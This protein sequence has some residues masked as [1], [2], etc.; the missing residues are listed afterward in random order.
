MPISRALSVLVVLAI[1]LLPV[2]SALV[3]PT[4]VAAPKKPTKPG[5]APTPNAQPKTKPVAEPTSPLPGSAPTP[6]V[7]PVPENMQ[8]IAGVD[9]QLDPKIAKALSRGNALSKSKVA[10]IA[11]K[12][13]IPADAND[14]LEATSLSVRYPYSGPGAYLSFRGAYQ[15]HPEAYPDGVASI[16]NNVDLRRV[17]DTG[18]PIVPAET[19][20]DLLR[21]LNPLHPEFPG[22]ADATITG[23][24]LAIHFVA[25]PDRDYVVSCRVTGTTVGTQGGTI[26]RTYAVRVVV[27]GDH[28]HMIR[29][30][31]PVN[32]RV[33]F[34]IARG[35]TKRG[36]D[37]QILAYK[38]DNL[39]TTYGFSVSRCD[40]SPIQ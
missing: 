10:S 39:P 25:A 4:A 2:V 30:L 18:P 5:P 13:S 24:Y 36:I 15:V 37:L 20:E 12:F 21:Q 31:D 23:D 33:S 9:P 8:P 26:T 40:I 38:A 6:T 17:R 34:G 32:G 1:P 3:E 14:V 7:L 11:A 28:H 22:D 27:D 35:M 19:G 16:G 29:G